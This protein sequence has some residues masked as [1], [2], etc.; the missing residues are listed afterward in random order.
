MRLEPTQL[1]GFNQGFRSLVPESVLGS[2][3][4]PEFEIAGF[5]V[6][7]KASHLYIDL[8][9]ELRNS[10][11]KR[12]DGALTLFEADGVP[13]RLDSTP[14]IVNYE[15]RSIDA[16]VTYLVGDS[17]SL[18]A[19]YQFI[20]A[21]VE[22]RFVELPQ[23]PIRQRSTFQRGSVFALINHPSGFH[24]RID[25]RWLIE[26]NRGLD[27]PWIDRDLF[28]LDLVIGYRA[29]R[30]RWQLSLGVLNL[31]DEDYPR[32]PFS[33]FTELPRERTLLVRFGLNL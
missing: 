30:Q 25:G 32:S 13:L 1:S 27:A 10:D 28:Q 31:T 9:A 12:V 3:A 26:N 24:G 20:N 6:T 21:A 33:T 29:L 16:S 14:E 5:G 8:A 17:W 23:P 22:R 2:V 15:E 19:R 18:G 4:G 7:W 11:F